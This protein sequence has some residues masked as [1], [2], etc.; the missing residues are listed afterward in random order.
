MKPYPNSIREQLLQALILK[1]VPL[2]K[3]MG[4][5]IFRSPVVAVLRE[6]TPAILVFPVEE[7]TAAQNTQALRKLTVRIVALA[8][9]VDGNNGEI[10]AD[11]LIV[12]IH[13][14]LMASNNLGGLCIKI[15]EIGTEWDIEDADARAVAIPAK[16]EIDYRTHINDLTLKI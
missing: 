8:R 7:T 10:V 11:Q 5:R 13:A 15:R 3:D 12:A 1:L 9:E 2:A 14:A 4:A 16:Y 6:Q